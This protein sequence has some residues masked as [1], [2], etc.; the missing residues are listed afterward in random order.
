[1]KKLLIAGGSHADI[2]LIQAAKQLGYHV[3]TSAHR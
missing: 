1:M 3:A 2:P